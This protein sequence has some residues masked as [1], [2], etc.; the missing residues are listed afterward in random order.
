MTTSLLP[1]FSPDS[2]QSRVLKGKP[3]PVELKPVLVRVVVEAGANFQKPRFS[4]DHTLS[5]EGEDF[6]VHA[7]GMKMVTV[8]MNL[9]GN[10]LK[11]FE[12]EVRV[13]C[14]SCSTVGRLLSSSAGNASSTRN[15]QHKGHCR[16]CHALHLF[17]PGHLF[18]DLQD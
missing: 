13:T 1:H 12:G 9:N 5:V 16:R 2:E 18:R 14:S 7:D 11:H 17:S 10:A 15:S 3:V 6:L 4:Q 8:L